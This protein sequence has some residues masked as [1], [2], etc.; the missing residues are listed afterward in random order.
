LARIQCGAEGSLASQCNP[1]PLLKIGISGAPGQTRLFHT[2][3]S[4]G[5]FGRFHIE[6]I[7]FMS[8]RIRGS[9][10]ILVG[11][12]ALFQG[13]QLF[14]RGLRD[15]HLWLEVVAGVVLIAL[16]IWRIR[17]KPVDPLAELLK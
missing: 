7:A 14:Q 8:D 1:V 16:G 9:I 5:A 2:S 10:A 6:G 11:V 17:R 12:F 3:Y 13:Y 4:D 15:W